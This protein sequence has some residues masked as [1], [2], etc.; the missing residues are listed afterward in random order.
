ML[1]RSLLTALVLLALPAGA[2]AATLGAVNH[3]AGSQAGWVDVDV[4]RPIESTQSGPP[5]TVTW[6]GPGAL[7]GVALVGAG[8]AGFSALP[9]RNGEPSASWSSPIPAGSYRLYLITAGAPLDLELRVPSLSGVH[10]HT[11]RHPIAVTG[12]AFTSRT[13]GEGRVI[14]GRTVRMETYGM[15]WGSMAWQFP[16][17]GRGD[18]GTCVY[19][20]G[21]EHDR[22]DEFGA[23]CP[24]TG[25]RQLLPG[26]SSSGSD[27]VTY[28]GGS[29][30]TGSR[31]GFG[32]NAR[33]TSGGTPSV[34]G[35]AWAINLAPAVEPDPFPYP[36]DSPFATP[37]SD[38]PAG[39]APAEPTPSSS[40]PA[41]LAQQV[42]PVPLVPSRAG[43]FALVPVSCPGPARCRVSVSAGTRP[44]AATIAPGTSARLRVLLTV[45][46]RRRLRSGRRARPRVKVAIRGGRSVRRTV[47]VRPG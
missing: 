38:R 43:R 19:L 16:A 17:G 31:W 33:A 2:D 13:D 14:G 30:E 47:T 41:A 7:K 36:A 45:A 28:G 12:G 1:R 11:V 46:D 15:V 5:F 32:A 8:N 35:E 27:L 39:P 6:T 25:Q 9:D 22:P 23:G 4:P 26:G 20:P 3:L 29:A 37:P 10:E 18:A 21:H 24:G 44:T 42:L 34:S 40:S